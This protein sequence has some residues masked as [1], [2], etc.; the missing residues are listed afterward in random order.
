[1][2]KIIPDKIIAELKGIIGDMEVDSLKL[3]KTMEL[4][5]DKTLTH[6][7]KITVGTIQAIRMYVL[8]NQDVLINLLVKGG[9]KFAKK[10]SS[11]TKR[12]K[13]KGTDY[14]SSA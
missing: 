1:L 5:G 7:V 14:A 9:E 4:I 2:S 6:T 11:K 12:V 10:S 13:G 8:A 3:S